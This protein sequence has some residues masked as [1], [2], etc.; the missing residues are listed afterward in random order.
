MHLWFFWG[1]G[2]GNCYEV[3]WS[4]SN[5]HLL[6]WMLQWN[7]CEAQSL[8]L[9]VWMLWILSGLTMTKFCLLTCILAIKA[10]QFTIAHIVFVL[11]CMTCSHGKNSP[12]FRCMSPPC[13]RGSLCQLLLGTYFPLFWVG[14][15]SQVLLLFFFY[16]LF[17]DC[18]PYKNPPFLFHLTLNGL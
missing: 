14:L 9:F 10:G 1:E 2:G 6:T 5:L 13:P 7:L 8:S 12:C 11:P 4:G 3:I 17:F 18:L 15:L 16:L